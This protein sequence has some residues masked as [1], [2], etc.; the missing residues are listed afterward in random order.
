MKSQITVEER[1][2]HLQR[3]IVMMDSRTEQGD[4]REMD[5]EV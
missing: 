2:S 5:G 4:Q 1:R 3:A